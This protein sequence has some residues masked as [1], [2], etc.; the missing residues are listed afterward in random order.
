[1]G[2]SELAGTCIYGNYLFVVGSKVHHS[3]GTHYRL[4]LIGEVLFI[5]AF[6][7]TGFTVQHIEH[8]VVMYHT[9]SVE[10]VH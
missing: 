5:A 4:R 7:F 3:I 1:M 6:L 8:V 9:V 10:R 2:P